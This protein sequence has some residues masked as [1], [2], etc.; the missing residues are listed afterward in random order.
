MALLNVVGGISKY[1]Y[2]FIV[3]GAYRCI[4]VRTLL[5]V[6]GLLSR[7]DFE[8]MRTAGTAVTTPTGKGKKKRADS[9]DKPRISTSYSTSRGTNER[10]TPHRDPHHTTSPHLF[11]GCLLRLL[12]G[13][14]F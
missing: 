3:F 8:A 11:V 6:C 4:P 7:A 1:I 12:S 5:H 14:K 2:K 10:V 9:K 13:A